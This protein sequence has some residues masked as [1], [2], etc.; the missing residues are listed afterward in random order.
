[1]DASQ[2]Q[3]PIRPFSYLKWCVLCVTGARL[4]RSLEVDAMLIQWPRM[5]EGKF[6][7]VRKTSGWLGCRACLSSSQSAG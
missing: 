7:D 6:R 4:S 5:V 2:L 1:M 3:G